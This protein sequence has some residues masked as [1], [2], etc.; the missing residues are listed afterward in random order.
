MIKYA[1][2]PVNA[3]D[4]DYFTIT[5]FESRGNTYS[6][7]VKFPAVGAACSPGSLFKF[8]RTAVLL[9]GGPMPLFLWGYVP[10]TQVELAS[11]SPEGLWILRYF[12]KNSAPCSCLIH[13]FFFSKKFIQSLLYTIIRKKQK[14]L[15]H[16]LQTCDLNIFNNQAWNKKYYFIWKENRCLKKFRIMLKY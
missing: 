3:H 16:C 9:K 13:A 15:Y 4:R 7:F 6:R 2:Q 8:R 5:W 1:R 14:S 12:L 10:R 11:G